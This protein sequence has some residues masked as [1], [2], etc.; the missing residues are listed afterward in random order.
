M[1]YK[2][3]Q[4]NCCGYKAN[5]NELLLLISELNPTTICFQETLKKKNSDKPNMENYEQYDYIH[6]TGLRA[7]GRVSIFTWKNIPQS[8]T[9]TCTIFTINAMCEMDI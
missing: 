3:I 6:D 7:L 9:N 1:T 8:K 5:Y 2:I 4:W